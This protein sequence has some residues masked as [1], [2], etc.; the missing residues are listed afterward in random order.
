MKHKEK[1][2][3]APMRAWQRVV[4]IF[5]ALLLAAGAG[6]LLFPPISNTVG[7]VRANSSIDAYEAALDTVI[8]PASPDEVPAEIAARVTA[9]SYAEAVER[10]E[11]DAEGYVID[12]EGRRISSSPVV[13]RYDLDK[14]HADSLA[15]NQSI[16]NHQGTADTINYSKAVFNLNRYGVSNVYGYLKADSIGLSLPIYLGASDWAMSCGGAH[17]YGT[18]LPLDQPD[19]NVAIA[20]HTG[21]VGRIFF[22][23]IRRLKAV[24]RVTV[25]NYWETIEYKVIDFKKVE[26][27][28]A[29]DI[30]IQPGRQLLT[31]ITCTPLGNNKYGRYLVICE[32]TAG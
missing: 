28:N 7:Q 1:K 13:F 19:T 25:T 15:Y 4:L 20:G 14:L 18:S 11:V 30:L 5:A 2:K 23:N 9:E 8:D 6:F 3:R 24:D 10:G 21:Y 16:I 26:K 12:T 32:K 22:D 27:N 31:L 17:L 29:N